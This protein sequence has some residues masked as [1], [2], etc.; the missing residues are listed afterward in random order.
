MVFEIPTFKTWSYVKSFTLKE[1]EKVLYY[2]AYI[3]TESGT[4]G[5][6]NGLDVGMF[7]EQQY[8]ELKE[9]NIDFKAGMGGDIIKDLL[10]KIDLDIENKEL[11]RSLATVTTE[12]AR[13]KIVKALKGYRIFN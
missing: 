13:A 4:H 9:S 12:M 8:H 1:L 7:F 2:E 11:R 3:V 6:E 10:R 5:V